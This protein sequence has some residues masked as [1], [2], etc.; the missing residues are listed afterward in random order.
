[1]EQV[2]EHSP[3]E[4]EQVAARGDRPSLLGEFWFFLGHNK[5]WWMLPILVVLLLMSL[6][7][8]LSTSAAAPFIYTLF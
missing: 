5:K 4:L 7:L 6:L 2:Q 8:V 3:C 1:M